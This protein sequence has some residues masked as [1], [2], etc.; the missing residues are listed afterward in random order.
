MTQTYSH[1][2]LCSSNDLK[3]LFS[4][5]DRMYG[6]PGAFPVVRCLSCS[7]CFLNHQ[8]TPEELSQYYPNTYYA[9]QGEETT[10]HRP[11]FKQWE[12]N[13]RTAVEH[14]ALSQFCAY[15]RQHRATP[16]VRFLAKRKSKK[17]AQLPHY[18]KGGKLLDVG[19]GGGNYLASMRKLGWHVE[20]IEPSHSGVEA[21][22]AQGITA[23]EGTLE[24]VYLPDHTFDFIRFEHVLEHVPDPLRALQEASR[25][26]KKKGII[27]VQVP[28]IDGLPARWFGTYWY[29]LDTPRH[30]FWFNQK[31]LHQLVTKANLSIKS[32]QIS[33]DYSD[34]SD[35]LIYWLKEYWPWLA[36]RMGQRKTLWKICN[37][38]LMPVRIWMNSNQ[39]GSIL[40]IEIQHH[41]QGI[42]K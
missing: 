3:L 14:E 39:S 26:L 4:G 11:R 7:L 6:N 15:P 20:G 31:T 22:L 38:I 17:Y 29:H 33:N 42:V 12:L 27:R 30:L 5:I 36:K 19:C 10:L 25:M 21:C 35:S 2:P 34:I 8:F 9:Y 24:S 28:N 23:H 37:K 41:D 32:S 40:T 16:L 18:I 1:C 13:L